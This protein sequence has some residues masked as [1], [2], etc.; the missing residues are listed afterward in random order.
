MK[1]WQL[2]CEQFSLLG[3]Q[4]SACRVKAK[5]TTNC[6]VWMEEQGCST[7]PSTEGE[8]SSLCAL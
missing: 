7:P 2:S 8:Q 4:K 1:V 6:I 3:T 5:A